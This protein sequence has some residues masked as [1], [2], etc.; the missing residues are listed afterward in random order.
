MDEAV[1]HFTYRDLR[2]L[3]NILTDEQ[4][5]CDVTIASGP[6]DK[7]QTEMYPVTDI[8]TA[9]DYVDILDEFHPVLISEF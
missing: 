6:I 3:L 9:G 1:K 2:D 5:D 7:E 8:V 4:L